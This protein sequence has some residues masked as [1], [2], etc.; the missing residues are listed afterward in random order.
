VLDLDQLKQVNDR[1][2][3]HAGDECL[4]HLAGVLAR[5]IRRGDWVARWGGDEF[6]VCSWAGGETSQ[7]SGEELLGRVA[8]EL[9]GSPV[10][11]G[12]G[13]EE[14]RLTFSAGVAH[15]RE[16]EGAHDLIARADEAL[17]R[18][19]QEEGVSVVRAD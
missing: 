6:V 16:G 8:E 11:L 4:A 13:E 18:A 3:H 19:K 1:H 7:S 12:A 9:R 2:G 14:V 5:N 17:Y 10:R 15:Y